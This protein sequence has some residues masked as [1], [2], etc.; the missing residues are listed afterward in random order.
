[1]NMS[2]EKWQTVSIKITFYKIKSPTHK[3]IQNDI[4]NF[5]SDT[6]YTGIYAIVVILGEHGL[7]LRAVWCISDHIFHA[8]EIYLLF[9]NSFLN[10]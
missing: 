6:K 1:M 5:D 9:Y 10:S 3:Y 8:D 2:L 7:T 4:E